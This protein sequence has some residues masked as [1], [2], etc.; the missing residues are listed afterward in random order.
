MDQN[1]VTIVIAILI[2]LLIL[3]SVK[4][5]ALL[6]E[7]ERQKQNCPVP[8]NNVQ[9]NNIPNVDVRVQPNVDPRIREFPP[10]YP[11]FFPESHDD[12]DFWRGYNDAYTRNIARSADLDYTNG[13]LVGNYDASLGYPYY[14]ERYRPDSVFLN[15]PF[16]KL[17]VR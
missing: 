1:K 2:F 11:Y 10:Q 8:Q 5:F 16:L 12:P 3:L 17:D 9:Q 14:Y 6:K 4:H 13:Y 15:L 7:Q